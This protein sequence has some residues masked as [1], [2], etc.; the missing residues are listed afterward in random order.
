MADS[1][2]DFYEVLGV[3]RDASEDEIRKAYRRLA[4]KYHPDLN[5]GDKAA[6]AKF[7]EVNEA[8]NVL[9]NKDSKARYDQFGHA[10]VDPSYGG[11][12]SGGPVWGSGDPF[13]GW[14]DIGDIFDSFFGGGF[15]GFSNTRR[16]RSVNA[17]APRRGTDVEI[18]L[19]VSFLEAAK[20]CKKK[21]S[22]NVI[23]V[24]GSCCGTGA[25]KGSKP[26]TCSTCGGSGQQV[27]TQRSAFG[28]MQTSR[29]CSVCRGTGK[30]VDKPCKDCYG[31]GSVRTVKELEV[32][33][34]AGIDEGQILNVSSHGNAG[35]NGGPSG[36]L[37]IAIKVS[38]HPIFTR[39]GYDIYCEMPITFAQAALGS[40]LVVPT[41]DG[42][43]SYSI[44]EGTQPGDTFRLRGKGIEHLRSGRRG[45]QYV[46][47]I[48]EVPRSLSSHQKEILKNFDKSL[49][50]GNYQKRKSFFEKLKDFFS[51]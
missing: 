36:D 21:I 17:N 39:K 13:G 32:T 20:G 19:E 4:K 30:V 45:D 46:K 14:G 16:S 47:V 42:K 10:G 18:S 48:L 15:G 37:H 24:C 11:Y 1:K 49:E 28:V 27:T 50:N 35:K 2:R 23:N 5:P 44:P 38:S 6:E 40:E 12:S 25:Q 33:I 8:Y 9:S 31:T 26:K 22:Y 51:D 41:L 43:V 3:G 34:P 29:T 7:K